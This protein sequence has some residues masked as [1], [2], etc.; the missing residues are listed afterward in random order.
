M[1]AIWGKESKKSEYGWRIIPCWERKNIQADE[2]KW[3]FQENKSIIIG[4][5]NKLDKCVICGWGK[6]QNK[7]YTQ[8]KLQETD[9][10]SSK[11]AG[12]VFGVTIQAHCLKVNPSGFTVSYLEN[13]IWNTPFSIWPCHSHP[14]VWLTA[15]NLHQFVTV[16]IRQQ[17]AMSTVNEVSKTKRLKCFC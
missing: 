14:L 12:T 10:G 16:W 9:K 1:N 15:A 6:L 13:S 11:I 2:E 5:R 8:S 17:K 4:Y 3:R 7:E